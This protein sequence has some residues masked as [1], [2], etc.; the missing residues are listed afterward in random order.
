MGITTPN[1]KHKAFKQKKQYKASFQPFLEPSHPHFKDSE[2]AADELSTLGE[3]MWC[4]SHGAMERK[5]RGL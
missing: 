5:L 2:K 4:P 1:L 3:L